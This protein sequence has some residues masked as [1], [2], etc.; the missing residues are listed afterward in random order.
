[1]LACFENK[2]GDGGFVFGGQRRRRIGS[3]G[4]SGEIATEFQVWEGL[5]A[6]SGNSMATSE[7]FGSN[8]EPCARFKILGASSVKAAV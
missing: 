2:I 6:V 1:M 5:V 8:F 4:G 7:H 3:C